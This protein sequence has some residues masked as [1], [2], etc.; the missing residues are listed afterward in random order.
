MKDT[1]AAAVA[2]TLGVSLH[3]IWGWELNARQ[4]GGPG[5]PGMLQTRLQVRVISDHDTLRK[6]QMGHQH[7][8]WALNAIDVEARQPPDVPARLDVALLYGKET[9]HIFKALAQMTVY[10]K[11]Q[12][13][14]RK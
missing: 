12:K 6:L 2:R 9:Q 3:H 7:G 4:D 10:R 14:K 5:V 1:V 11:N 8:S 13:S